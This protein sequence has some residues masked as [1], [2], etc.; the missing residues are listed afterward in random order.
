MHNSEPS[1]GPALNTQ[2]VPSLNTKQ[3]M[4][5]SPTGQDNWTIRMAR[6]KEHD[7]CTTSVG[8]WSRQVAAVSLIH[9]C[10]PDTSETLHHSVVAASDELI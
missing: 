9:D 5:A 7:L 1:W 6:A 4:L 2:A 10:S 8:S 3:P